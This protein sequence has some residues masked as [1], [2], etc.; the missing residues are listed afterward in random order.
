MPIAHAMWVHGHGTRVEYPERLT[1]ARRG[2]AI[3][4][5]GQADSTNWLHIGVPTTVITDDVRLRV[6]SVMIRF[7]GD[8]V[9]IVA[10]HV[11]DG[12][13]RIAT[14]DPLTVSS[15][16]WSTPRW[17]V[18]NTPEIRWGLGISFKVSY[19]SGSPR[20]LEVSA[21]GADFTV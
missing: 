18:P 20:R 10:V 21:G 4:L 8:G 11:Y 16:V 13:T 17:D 14:H 12:E 6:Q 7:K 19:G 9:S 5:D 2:S 3:R 1:I 15:A